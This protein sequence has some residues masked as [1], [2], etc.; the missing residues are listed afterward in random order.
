MDGLNAVGNFLF[1]GDDE[2]EASDEEM[3]LLEQN[4][5]IMCKPESFKVQWEDASEDLIINQE[6]ALTNRCT[7]VCT[8]CGGL[9]SISDDGQENAAFEQ[10]NYQDISQLKEGDAMPEAS[11][12]NLKQLKQM[13]QETQEEREKLEKENTPEAKAKIAEAKAKEEKLKKLSSKMEERINERDKLNKELQY[14]QNIDQGKYNELLQQKQASEN[15]YKNSKWT[16]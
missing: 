2:E 16:I 15:N 11:Q 3:T 14:Y 6:H 7:I 10:Q 1:G 12:G 9:V 8:K 4:V 13:E 5:T